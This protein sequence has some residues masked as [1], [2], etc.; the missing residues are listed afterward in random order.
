MTTRRLEL[1]TA[2]AFLALAVAGWLASAGLP[3]APRL[4]PR[5]VLAV[6]GLAAAAWLA[7]LLRAPAAAGDEP[8]EEGGRRRLLVAFGLT[9]AYAA[10]VVTIGFFVV[11]LVYIPVMARFLGHRSWPWAIVAA[12]LY[13]IVTYLLFVVLF[14]RPVPF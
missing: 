7:G 11:T 3:P 9:L 6:L 2:T 10:A 12:V 1:V 4:F 14:E 8:Q 5:L 13:A